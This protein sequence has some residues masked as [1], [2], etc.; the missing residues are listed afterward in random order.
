MALNM[1]TLVFTAQDAG[2]DA[3]TGNVQIAPTAVVTAAGLTVVTQAPVVR[4]LGSG[5]VSVSLVANDNTGTS[6]AAG[7]WA[8][9]ITLPGGVT[10][11]YLVNF[12]NGA[13]QQ[14]SNLTPAVASTTYGAAAA[15]VSYPLAL[16]LGGTGAAAG[17]DAALL[18]ALGA[19]ALAGATFTGPVVLAVATLAFATTMTPVASGAGAAQVWNVPLTASTGTIANPS[20]TPQDGQQMRFRIRQDA[21]GGRT[22]AWGS[23]YDWGSASGTPNS[24]PV[25]S[26]TASVADW[27]A[28]EWDAAKSKWCSL[29][30]AFPQGF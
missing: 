29:G 21:T 20:G 26:T 2:D 23:A 3:A 28:V 12:G 22:V 7:F 25:L 15:S 1:V 5:T 27:V 17:S 10:Q 6:P 4:A 8:Y 13:T 18:A 11:P 9:N 30:A 24:A 19:A 14:F 16:S